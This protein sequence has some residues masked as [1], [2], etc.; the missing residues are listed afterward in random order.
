MSV[1]TEELEITTSVG[2]RMGAYL[3][4]PEGDAA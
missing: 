1:K 2:E 3:A 4:R